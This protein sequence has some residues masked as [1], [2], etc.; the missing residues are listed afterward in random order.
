MLLTIDAGNTNVVFSIFENEKIIATWR[1]ATQVTRTA[2]DYAVW[3]TQLMALKKIKPDHIKSAILVSVV[4][5]T[6]HHLKKL[7]QTWFHTEPVLVQTDKID[8]GIKINLPRPQEVG[9]DRLVNAVAV[10]NE[11]KVPAIVIDFGTA[12]TF[13]IINDKGEYDGGVI[14]PGVNLSLSALYDAAARLPRVA[15]KKP[16]Q[17]IGTNTVDAMQSGIFWGYVSMIE[18]MVEKI[19]KEYG[20]KMNVIATGGL[21]AMMAEPIS[22]IQHIDPDLTQKG[23]LAL[24]NKQKNKKAA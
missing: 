19:S 8:F 3:V 12:T 9:E 21:A 10:V 22:I 15:V 14:A 2:D 4:P 16:D 11:Y 17:V 18:G 23:L 1:C 6:V 7:C 5:E 24:Y 13:D 20:K